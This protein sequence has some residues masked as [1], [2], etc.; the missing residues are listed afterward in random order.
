[1]HAAHFARARRRPLC[2]AGGE[3]SPLRRA[4]SSNGHLLSFSCIFSRHRFFA[5]ER[6]RKSFELWATLSSGWDSRLSLL[7]ALAT[8]RS[9]FRSSA[10]APCPVK[11]IAQK[12]HAIALQRLQLYCQHY[13]RSAFVLFLLRMLLLF[14]LLVLA[15]RMLLLEGQGPRPHDKIRT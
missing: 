1:M 8:S 3:T 4:C 5:A 15:L 12:Q 9:R 10:C 11:P 2:T 7:D 14:I 6:N 13:C